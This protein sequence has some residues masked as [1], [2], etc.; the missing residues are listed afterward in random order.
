[1]SDHAGPELPTLGDKGPKRKDD[2]HASKQN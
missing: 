2:F 1:M